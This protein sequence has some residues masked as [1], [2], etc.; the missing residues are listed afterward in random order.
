MRPTAGPLLAGDAVIVTGIAPAPHAFL[1]KDGTPAPD[2]PAG[3][4]VAAP[5]AIVTV[6]S[7]A[8]PFLIVMTTD[9]VKGSTVA[10]MT[11]SVD[12]AVA[13]SLSPLPNPVMPPPTLTVVNDE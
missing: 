8:N 2:L 12:P 6:P 1:T 7:E 3:G 4:V 11:R 13:P 5:P 9:I 10:A